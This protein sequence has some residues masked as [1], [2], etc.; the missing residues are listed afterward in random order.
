MLARG[1]SSLLHQRAWITVKMNAERFCNGF[2]FG[3]E[4]VEE[5]A[6]WIETGC[7][8]VME[9]CERADGIGRGIENEFGPLCAAS[10]FQRNRV[11]PGACEQAG[12]LLD[13]RHRRGRRLE[14]SDP[15]VALDVVADVAGR[16]GVTGGKG[17]AANH[18]PYMLGDQLFV[19]CTVL[20]GANGAASIE[21]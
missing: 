19:A 14:G 6:R 9:E 5:L 2:T 18:Q 8:A 7:C 3:D 12:E 16:D 4:I 1:V 10:V 20:H 17:C 21:C 11:H 13:A 15:S